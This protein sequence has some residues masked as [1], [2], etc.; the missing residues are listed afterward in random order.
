MATQTAAADPTI[1]TLA[2]P[3]RLVASTLH[4]QAW[5][6]EL[7]TRD[8]CTLGHA[9]CSRCH[10]WEQANVLRPQPLCILWV[11]V[12]GLLDVATLGCPLGFYPGVGSG[13]LTCYARTKLRFR[14]NMVGTGAHDLAVS[15]CCT[16]IATRQQHREMEKE[17]VV[18][19]APCGM[20]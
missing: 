15:C 1:H 2:K 10:A 16:H 14:F 20:D 17:G 8:G 11:P 19:P 13:C 6:Y 3:P 18:Y 7:F 12:I 4:Y 5:D 9:L